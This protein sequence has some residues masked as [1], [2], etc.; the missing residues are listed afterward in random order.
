MFVVAIYLSERSRYSTIKPLCPIEQPQYQRKQL[1]LSITLI[2]LCDTEEVV[3]TVTFLAW[4]SNI[5]G[6][7]L[8]RNTVTL[9]GL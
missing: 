8:G 7:H 4:V 9:I 2:Y 6:S 1:V 5:S 3:I